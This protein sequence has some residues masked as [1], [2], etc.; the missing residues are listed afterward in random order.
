MYQ[1][2]KQ[3]IWR[4]LLNIGAFL[5]ASICNQASTEKSSGLSGQEEV[6]C[7]LPNSWGCMGEAKGGLTLRDMSLLKKKKPRQDK[8]SKF[9]SYLERRSLG[10]PWDQV[11]QGEPASPQASEEFL[12]RN[13]MW[14]FRIVFYKLPQSERLTE[15]HVKPYIWV[16]HFTFIWVG[17]FSP[18]W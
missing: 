9:S 6:V 11:G 3:I 5:S 8:P 4:Y 17:F 16:K 18:F 2:L 1:F 13:R 14:K 12:G 7:S 10:N 15:F